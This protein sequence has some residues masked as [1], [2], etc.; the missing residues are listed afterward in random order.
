MRRADTPQVR[1]SVSFLSFWHESRHPTDS[2]VAEIVSTKTGSVP[3]MVR[4]PIFLCHFSALVLCPIM[5]T[6]LL[7]LTLRILSSRDIHATIHTNRC[8]QNCS[9]CFCSAYGRI[10]KRNQIASACF[11]TNK[12]HVASVIFRTHD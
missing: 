4:S 5:L 8:K 3:E 2:G 10:K 6:K 12:I 9:R 1:N 7:R 11:R